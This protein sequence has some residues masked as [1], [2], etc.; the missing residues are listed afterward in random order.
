MTL[1][2]LTGR[3]LRVFLKQP[4]F[5]FVTLIQ[6]AIWLFLFGN[7]FRRIVDLPGFGGGSYL[8][9]LVPGVVVMSAVSSSMW[10]GMGVLEE[11]DRG[12]MNRFLTTPARRGSILDAVVIEQALSVTVQSGWPPAPATRSAGSCCSSCPPRCSAWCSAPCRTRP[13]CW[14]ASARPS[15]ASTRCCCCR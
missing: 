12:T 3:R 1:L 8:T 6:P 15:S 14:S 4:A 7:L 5:L 13:A 10:S 9:Y 11:I 2:Y